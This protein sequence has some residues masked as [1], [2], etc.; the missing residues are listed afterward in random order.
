MNFLTDIGFSKPPVIVAEI[1]INHNGI[2]DRA[3]YLADLAIE[4]GA[5]V[6][7]SQI[8]IP[9]EEMSVHAKDIIPGHCDISIYEIMQNCSLSLEDELVFKNYIESKGASYLSTPFSMHAAKFLGSELQ[10]SAFKIGSGECN[11]LPLLR[12]VASY[13]KPVILST[14][15]NTLRD[16]HVSYKFLLKHGCPKVYLLHTTNIYPT[17]YNLVRLEC[18]RELQQIS[19]IDS[20]GLSDH[21][22]CNTA[23]LGAVALGAVLLERH[24]IDSKEASGPDIPNSMTPSELRQLKNQSYSM[25][26]MRGGSKI[27]LVEAE[28]DTRNFAF[29]TIVVTRPLCAGHILTLADLTPKRPRLG[30]F[31]ASQIFDLVGQKL[32]E[33]I[34][35]DTHLLNHHLE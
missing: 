33:D 25:F 4:S 7:K 19:S 32:K 9:S 29:A 14:G 6:V 23:C 34:D 31:A 35:Y 28:E 20:V 8:H 11:N 22:I 17:P 16:V 3:I 5:D 18:I 13:Q 24:F 15:M 10:V 21:T 26:L 12:V 2:L 27:D 1:G 30:D